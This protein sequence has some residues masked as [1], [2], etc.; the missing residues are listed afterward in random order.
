LKD[1]RSASLDP[2]LRATLGYLEILTLRPEEV[3]PADA[4]AVRATGVTGAALRDAIQVAFIFNLIDRV[5]DALG[6][7]IPS[8]E[9][10]LRTANVLIN[11][12]Y[13]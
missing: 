1:W 10:V 12:G 3:G 9:T 8:F 6:F 7:E 5:A 11:R 2:K 13:R 4:K